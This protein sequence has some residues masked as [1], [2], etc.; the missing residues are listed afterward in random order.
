L[1]RDALIALGEIVNTHATHGELRVRLYN[2]TSTTLTRDSTVVLRRGAE[3]HEHRIIGLRPHKRFVLLT[4]E[5]CNSMTAAQGLV[6]SEVCVPEADLPAPGPDEV[7]HYE[8]LGM[9]VVT[10]AGTT[11]GE[12]TEVIPAGSNDVCV[13]HGAG[14]EHLIPLVAD[15]VRRV[16]RD[17]CRLVIEPLPG[18]LDP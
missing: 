17:G 8:L 13:V 18:L 10:T 6:G 7:Y 2:P 1:A 4:L 5:G 3:E 12:V 14:G 15:V 11:I 16:D 9:T